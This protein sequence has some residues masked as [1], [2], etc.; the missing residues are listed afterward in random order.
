MI[1]GLYKAPP[2]NSRSNASSWSLGISGA[3][4]S[5]LSYSWRAS[6]II[7]APSLVLSFNG[8][9]NSRRIFRENLPKFVAASLCACV[10]SFNFRNVEIVAIKPAMR[11]PAPIDCDA[12]GRK[13]SGTDSI[14]KDAVPVMVDSTMTGSEVRCAVFA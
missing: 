13:F 1:S 6:S 14:A 4:S 11:L 5:S 3:S 8:S 9:A 12:I 7:T 10:F 2:G